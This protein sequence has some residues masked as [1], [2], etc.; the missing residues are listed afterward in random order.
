LLRAAAKNHARVTVVCDPMDYDKVFSEIQINGDTTEETRQM[1]ALKAFT[2]L[3][4]MIVPLRIT[5]EK[6]FQQMFLNLH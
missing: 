4:N 3:L 5:S 1:L 6:N 2:Q